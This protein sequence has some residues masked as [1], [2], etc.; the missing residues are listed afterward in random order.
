MATEWDPAFELEPA[1]S[2][3]PAYGALEIRTLKTATQ[4]R[5]DKEHEWDPADTSPQPRHGLHKAG[6]AAVFCQDSEP[7]TR[8]GVA[9]SADDAGITWFDT[10]NFTLKVYDGTQWLNA[11]AGVATNPGINFPNGQF[12]GSADGWVTYANTVA[13]AIPEDGTGGTPNTTFAFSATNPLI[14][15]GMGVLTKNAPTS[16]LGEGVS[17]DFTVDLAARNQPLKLTFNYLTEGTYADND[18]GCYLY[19]VTNAVLM[20]PSIVNIP[21]SGSYPAKFESSIYLNATSGSYR[22]IFHVQVATTAAFTFKLD[23]V[24]VQPLIPALGAAISEWQSYT[25]SIEGSITNPTKGTIVTDIGKWRRVGSN[26]EVTYKYTQSGGGSIGSGFYVFTLP[27]GYTID[28]DKISINS[29]IGSAIASTSAGQITA[30][31]KTG[32]VKVGDGNSK[33]YLQLQNDSVLTET[34]LVG[35]VFFDLQQSSLSYYFSFSVPISQW[36]SNINLASDFTEYASNTGTFDSSDLV[37]TYSYNGSEGAAFDNTAITTVRTKRVYW[38]R[39]IQPSDILKIEVSI[40]G[41]WYPIESNPKTGNSGYI[42]EGVTAFGAYFTGAGVNYSN[43]AFSLY[44]APSGTGSTYGAAGQ[45]WASWSNLYRWRVRKVSNGNMAEVPPVVRADYTG[46]TVTAASTAYKFTTKVED[47]H[48]SYD[49]ATGRFTA[50]VAG[51]YLISGSLVASTNTWSLRWTKSDATNRVFADNVGNNSTQQYNFTIR[52]LQGQY[53]ELSSNT[54]IGT[55]GHF[56]AT[57]L[58]H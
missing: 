33:V 28:Y 5:M 10:V 22:L 1:D 41:Y 46:Q 23:N 27:S 7:T 56:T 26:I 47:T 2:D 15:N 36:T 48:N 24:Q 14:G 55:G 3:S 11:G 42:N 13:A 16:R 39:P 12:T 49:P 19:D 43:I 54:V 40:G 52:L 57:Y 30:T 8:N 18:L 44:S 53:F 51:I 35:A 31:T 50:P 4:E 37:G 45:T 32:V 58:G 21:A 38:K 20:Y 17:Y 9:L 6:S 34:S 25:C 29:V